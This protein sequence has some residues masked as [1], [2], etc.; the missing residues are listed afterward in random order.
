M[1]LEIV[2]KLSYDELRKKYRN[3]MQNEGFG[4]SSIQT[5]YSDTFYLWRKERPDVFWTVVEA[6][7]FEEIAQTI[8]KKTIKQNSSGNVDS[9]IGGY[10]SHLRRFRRFLLRDDEI[11]TLT[12]ESTEKK[13]RKP[14][15]PVPTNEQVEHYLHVWNELENY[16]LQEEALDKLFLSLCPDN[17]D[18]CDI[19]LKVATLNDFYSTNIFSVYPV[20]KHIQALNI[21]GR[22][23]AG[24]ITLISE[25]QKV[26]INNIEKNFYSFATKYCSHHNP[27]DYPIYDIYVDK[28]LCYFRDQDG[29]TSFKAE[30]LKDY[31]KFKGILIDFR[32]FY[33]L[34][35]YNLKEID[36][37]IWQLG[38]E[39]FPKN[40]RKN[41]RLKK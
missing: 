19:L 2:K 8:L 29:F 31:V 32:I 7:D 25:I 11:M 14:Q 22:L 3:Y 38:K 18:I 1:N 13:L 40:Y 6:P 30:D 20:A 33:G 24:D 39:W 34:E 9:L 37:Y 15:V 21:D 16:Y 27:T 23:K 5:A 36:K 28:V 10:M 17:K 41:E 35:K 26:T 12:N 4:K